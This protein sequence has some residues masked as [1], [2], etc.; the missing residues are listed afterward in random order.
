MQL[1]YCNIRVLSVASDHTLPPWIA[2]PCCLS[3]QDST[4]QSIQF[5]CVYLATK[6]VDR[7]PYLEMLRFMLTNLYGAMVTRGQ[8]YEV[9]G[10]CLEGLKW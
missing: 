3:S 9:E 2:C 4:L 10:K 6:I 8:A 1:F 7:M 5:T